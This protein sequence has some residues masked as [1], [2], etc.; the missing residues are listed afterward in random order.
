[1]KGFCVCFWSC[2]FGMHK[3]IKI[4]KNEVLKY[5]EFEKKLLDGKSNKW[6]MDWIK[7]KQTDLG[8]DS[9][10]RNVNIE[11]INQSFNIKYNWT[12]FETKLCNASFYSV[13]QYLI[14]WNWSTK[15]FDCIE[16]CTLITFT[17]NSVNVCHFIW[18]WLKSFAEK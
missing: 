10:S 14:F 4:A 13:S 17:L 3:L 8:F 1:M 9:E 2:S 16:I 15:S 11:I 5:F 18:H 7:M 6:L 12:N